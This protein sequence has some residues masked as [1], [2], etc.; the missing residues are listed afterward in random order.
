MTSLTSATIVFGPIGYRSRIRLT[1]RITDFDLERR[2][3]IRWRFYVFDR[4]LR[5]LVLDAIE[6]VEVSFRT[7][8]TH[9]LALAY[10]AH[11]HLYASLFGATHEK[12]LALLVEET[13]RSSET[14]IGHYKRAYCQSAAKWDPVSASNRDPCWVSPGGDVRS[15]R[16]AQR[17]AVGRSQAPIRLCF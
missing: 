15:P 4:E 14:F 1:H 10:G 12:C 6:R 16:V 13:E 8:F 17:I 5:L 11:P 7:A 3:R 9:S 2:S